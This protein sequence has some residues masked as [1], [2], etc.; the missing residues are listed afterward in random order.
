[1]SE[2]AS[3][4]SPLYES[5]STVYFHHDQFWAGTPPHFL[6]HLNVDLDYRPDDVWL[7]SYPRSGTTWTY[8]VICAVL[9]EGNITALKQAQSEKRIPRFLP[10]E[11][12]SAAS[13]PDRINTETIEEF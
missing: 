8:E 11:I 7:S 13:V 4:T 9:Y 2:S 10:I 1:M 3:K 12:G 5:L 6:E